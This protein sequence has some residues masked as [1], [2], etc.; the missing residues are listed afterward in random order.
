MY[1]KYKVLYYYDNVKVLNIHLC[2]KFKNK[3]SNELKNDSLK[4][5]V[6]KQKTKYEY[7]LNSS[8]KYVLKSKDVINQNYIY[9]FT[10]DETIISKISNNDKNIGI[11][12]NYILN[13]DGQ[14]IK[15]LS[16]NIKIDYKYKN[17]ILVS[18]KINGKKFKI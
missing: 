4:S 11:I 14:M 7:V 13:K 2:D 10:N 5:I 18:I 8:D 6:K 9:D 16:D 12:K 1:Y 15:Y 17:N 3:E